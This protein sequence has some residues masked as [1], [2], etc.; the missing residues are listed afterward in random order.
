MG[1]ELKGPVLAYDR[2]GRDSP[3]SQFW[4]HKPL[5]ELTVQ[6]P[7]NLNWP[8]VARILS[9]CPWTWACPEPWNREQSSS[10]R[11]SPEL[12]TWKK[13]RLWIILQLH[14]FM[15][16][17]CFRS[18]LH[19]QKDCPSL[20]DSETLAGCMAASSSMRSLFTK[21]GSVCNKKLTGLSPHSQA[22][23][24]EIPLRRTP[25]SVPLVYYCSFTRFILV[26]EMRRPLT[27][28]PQDNTLITGKSAHV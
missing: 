15:L 24:H 27:S 18:W 23:W 11:A 3:N 22:L 6:N 13:H 19:P 28:S 26:L 17:S 16:P 8:P 10:K 5:A 2:A 1:L 20:P 21:P 7:A 25:N 4:S 9:I 14:S 12:V